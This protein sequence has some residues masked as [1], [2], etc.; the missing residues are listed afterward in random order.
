VA[1]AAARAFV[2]VIPKF[3]YQH[4]LYFVI[5]SDRQPS[6]R[7]Q[8]ESKDLAFFDECAIQ[9]NDGMI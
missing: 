9:S 4:T 7:G 1:R 2:F 3:R 5:L 6:L 8:R